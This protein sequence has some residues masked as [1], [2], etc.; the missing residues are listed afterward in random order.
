VG[1]DT[2]AANVEAAIRSNAG[3]NLAS[4]TLFDRYTGAPL[5][6]DEVSLAYRL[7]FQPGA[8]QLSE[9]QLDEAIARVTKALEREVKGRIR[10][11]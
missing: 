6:E 5:A 4:V 8:E 11:G 9:A 2:P 3:P 1:R 7:R 10:A